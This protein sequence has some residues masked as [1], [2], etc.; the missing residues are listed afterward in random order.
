MKQEGR[1]V[2]GPVAGGRMGCHGIESRE[3]RLEDGE[4]RNQGGFRGH[5]VRLSMQGP[6]GIWGWFF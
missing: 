6:V 4:Q 2:K 1:K 3:V 5:E